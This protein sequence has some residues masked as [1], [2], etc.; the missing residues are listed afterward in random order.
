MVEAKLNEKRDR[1][2]VTFSFSGETPAKIKSIPGRSFTPEQRGG[3]YWSLPLD[4]IS[5]KKLRALFDGQLRWHPELLA[6][7]REQRE[8]DDGLQNLAHAVD[9]PLAE[10]ALAQK[11]PQLAEWFRPYQRADVAYLARTNALNCNEQG[12]GKT[13]EII[14]AVYEAGLENGP[15]LISAPVT[16]LEVVWLEELTRWQKIPVLASED[17]KERERMVKRALEMAR[18]GEPFWLCVNPGMIRY[19]AIKEYDQYK[20]KMVEVGVSERYP[21]L[22][23]IEWSTITVDEFHKMGLNNPKTLSSRALYALKAQ[24]RYAMSGTPMGGRPLKLYGAL[25]FIEPK[26][27]SAK[28][29]WA[30]T[31]LEITTGYK[32]SREI[33]GIIPGKEDEFYKHHSRHMVRHLKSEVLPQLPP[34]QRVDVWCKMTPKQTKQYKQF[35]KDAE[36]RI[37]EFN[38]TATGILAEYSRLKFFATAYCNVEGKL[39]TCKKCAGSGFFEGVDC[40]VC[41][42]EGRSEKLKL[43]PT[44]D[45]GKLP[46]LMDRLAESGI[47]KDDPS[48]D[49]CAI[50][51]SQ[52]VEVVE[53]VH[54]YLNEQGITAEKITGK[55]VKPG[56]RRRLVQAFQGGGKGAPRVMCLSTLAGGVAIT[57][58]RADT[59]HVLDETWV[60][61]DQEQLIDRIHRASRLHQVTAYFY[62]SKD[63]LEEYI[64]EVNQ[65]KAFSNTDIL[66]IRRNGFR[67]IKEGSK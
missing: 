5:A 10:L 57:L 47:E 67:A 42:G 14:A 27:Y 31:W 39:V 48:G 26:E 35:A 32:N 25:K 11:L 52:S 58:D 59:A 21:E 33:G 17:L 66:D 55:T 64:Y 23:E 36:L 41:F 8:K 13:T 44:F 30:E 46:Y 34:K 43:K 24:R 61:D 62:R 54:R 60:P 28:W 37:D 1:I 29:R 3:P 18:A 9:Y 65:E 40:H 63:T 19:E 50:V 6:W 51:G 53:M 38:L 2:V 7:G 20:G 16:S 15:H 56:E 4:M 22:F 49:A 45:S 12:L